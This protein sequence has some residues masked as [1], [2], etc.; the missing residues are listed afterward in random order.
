MPKGSATSGL[1]VLIIAATQS[2]LVGSL[3]TADENVAAAL[4]QTVAGW[5]PA[6]GATHN[7]AA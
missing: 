3:A 6:P 1:D 5:Q 4:S 2:A 7:I